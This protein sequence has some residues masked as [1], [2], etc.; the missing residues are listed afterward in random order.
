MSKGNVLRFFDA[1]QGVIRLAASCG[2]SFTA[3]EMETVLKELPYSA[4]SLPQGWGWPLARRMGLVR[5]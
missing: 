1:A 4:K 5:G 3:E 2:L